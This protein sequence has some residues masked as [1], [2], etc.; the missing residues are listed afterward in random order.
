MFR[1]R[2]MRRNASTSSQFQSHAQYGQ[3]AFIWQTFFK[4][5][6]SGGY[7]LDVGAYD[8]TTFSNT[9]LFEDSLNWDG[10]LFEPNPVLFK[11]LKENRRNECFPCGL[12]TQNRTLKFLQCDG[13]GE[14][15]SCFVEFASKEHL[16]RIEEDRAQHDF[17]VREIDVDV[18]SIDE[19]LLQR[20][21]RKVDYLSIDV[22]GFEIQLLQSFP[23]ERV[24]VDVISVEANGDAIAMEAFLHQKGFRLAGIVGTDH[25]YVAKLR[26]KSG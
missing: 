1:Q 6:N 22:E 25:I 9:K 16:Q 7:F 24:A 18:K 12:G 13:Y 2:G 23:F 19:F 20:E 21:I 17:D 4:E 8:G 11:R 3:D 26:R 10:V 15:L 14:M 5:C